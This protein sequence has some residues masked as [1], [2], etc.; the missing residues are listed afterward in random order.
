MV[1]PQSRFNS[2]KASALGAGGDEE[3]EAG[4]S[5]LVSTC[6][7]CPEANLAHHTMSVLLRSRPSCVSLFACNGGDDSL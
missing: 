1:G 4:A 5:E 3:K 6:E 2:P 7:G